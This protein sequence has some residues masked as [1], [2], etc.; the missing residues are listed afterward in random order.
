MS[1]GPRPYRPNPLAAWFLL[2]TAAAVL[3]AFL[4]GF[5]VTDK[6]VLGAVLL[7]IVL[8]IIGLCFRPRLRNGSL[9]FGAGIVM[10]GLISLL[11]TIP[12]SDLTY[13]FV[14]VLVG[15]ILIIVVGLAG[16]SL[17]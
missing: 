13:Q 3:F 10:G 5:L 6:I 11:A 16:R 7:P 9:G 4:P 17:R 14:G 8:G 1:A 2:L 12:S 15:S